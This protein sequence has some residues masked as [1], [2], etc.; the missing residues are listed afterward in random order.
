MTMSLDSFV[1]SVPLPMAKPTSA[2]FTAG[3]SFTPSPV[4]PTTR[5]I[6]FANLTRRL[7]SVGKAL[8][9]T[10]NSGRSSFTWSSLSSPSSEEVITLGFSPLMIPTSRAMAWAVS[11]ESPVIITTWIPACRALKTAG[12][13]CGRISSR[14]PNT[15]TRVNF[16]GR[17]VPFIGSSE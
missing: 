8:A 1:I 17:L 2:F 4:I 11:L 16:S 12:L 9:T 3:A 14:S 6:C 7:L 10:H 13:D 15:E 5:F